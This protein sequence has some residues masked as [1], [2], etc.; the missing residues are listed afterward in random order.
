MSKG[1]YSQL[2]EK[3]WQN[4]VLEAAATFGWYVYHTYDSRRSHPGFPDLV[5]VKPPRVIFAEL[6]TEK[7]IVKP[8]QWEWHAALVECTGVD[9]YLWRPS[10]RD[11]VVEI[12]GENVIAV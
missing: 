12:L 4:F 5:L 10:D 8:A 6:K 7:G 3:E 11:E 9:T 1:L 2:K